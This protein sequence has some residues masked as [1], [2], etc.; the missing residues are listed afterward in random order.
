[1]L[2]S[3][4]SNSS[5]VLLSCSENDH[6]Y[7]FKDF[8]LLLVS[9]I[10]GF[11]IKMQIDLH[12]E[13]SK[14]NF[15]HV[16]DLTSKKKVELLGGRFVIVGSYVNGDLVVFSILTGKKVFHKKGIPKTII[17][18]NKAQNLVL[19]GCKNGLLEVYEV[20]YSEKDHMV[21]LIKISEEYL[22]FPIE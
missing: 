18:V 5:L 16:E 1:M 20:V 4:D 22:M 21:T 15:Y 6:L 17:Y 8:N 7:F 9:L 2:G 12:R 3:I 14:E 19:C 13:T 11:Q 10:E